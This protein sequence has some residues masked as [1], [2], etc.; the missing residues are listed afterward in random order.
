MN[1]FVLS[2]ALVV[3]CFSGNVRLVYSDTDTDVA[4]G[5]RV[6]T[7]CTA[8]HAPG[9]HRTGPKHCGL[10]GR[11]AGSIAEFEFTPA[12]RDSGILWT[13]ETL[14]QF[15]LA[16]LEMVPGTSMGFAGVSI[17][18]ERIQLIAFLATLTEDNPLCR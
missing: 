3:F 17:K 16:P 10:L 2:A 18:E 6:Y 9:Y 5:K 12:M 8:C 13:K 1:Q 15:L 14:Y 4:A 11:R 7:Q